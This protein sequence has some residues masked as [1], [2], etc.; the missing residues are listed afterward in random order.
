MRD[1]IPKTDPTGLEPLIK[2]LKQSNIKP[3]DRVVLV[4]GYFVLSFIVLSIAYP[5]W[6][7]DEPVHLL[8]P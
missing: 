3:R 4:F 6:H 7:R 1:D 2:R 8:K 5:I